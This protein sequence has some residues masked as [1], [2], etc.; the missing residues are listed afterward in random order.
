MFGLDEWIAQLGV[1]H[2]LALAVL[3]A[4]L[5]GLRHATDPDHLV[6]VA[7]L[8]AGE[9]NL[10]AR[11]GA[12]MGL[13]WGAGHATTLVALGLPIVMYA[14]YLPARAQQLAE[15]AVGAL[16]VALAVR[17]LVR[18][19]RDLIHA[20]EHDHDGSSHR[21]LHGHT[22]AEPRRH[23]GRPIRSMRSAYGIGLVHGLGGSAG[24][25]LLLLA[26]IDSRPLAVSALLIFATCSALSMMLCSG[27]LGWLLQ[28]RAFGRRLPSLVPALSVASML[29]GLW[30]M[31]GALQLAPYPL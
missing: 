1:G 8:A 17:L 10:G 7:T 5:V 26:G 28:G 31:A 2:P 18:R 24:V 15:A 30:Y 9:S 11:R 21:H 4:A 29:F 27:T 12:R 19:R 23:A 25:G 13:A 14:S 22:S 3:V 6:A 20:H 16:I